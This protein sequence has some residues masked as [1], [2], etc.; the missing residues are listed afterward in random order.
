MSNKLRIEIF[1]GDPF[2]GA[3]CRPNY[4]SASRCNETNIRQMLMDRNQIIQQIERMFGMT[5][6]I[7]REIL[8]QGGSPPKYVQRILFDLIPLPFLFLNGELISSGHFPSYDEI[9]SLIKENT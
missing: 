1:E 5:I 9:V 2:E 4:N 6:S 3:C 8:G 7:S